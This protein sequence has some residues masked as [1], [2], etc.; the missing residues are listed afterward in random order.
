MPLSVSLSALHLSSFHVHTVIFINDSPIDTSE[1]W[2]LA[3]IILVGLV[4]LIQFFFEKIRKD[5]FMDVNTHS[6]TFFRWV[7]EIPTVLM[8][9][10]VF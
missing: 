9:L 6:H 8:I 2:F 10:I 3:K 1:T 4:S 5:F 7:N